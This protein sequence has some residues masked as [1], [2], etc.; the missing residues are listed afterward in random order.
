M[1]TENLNPL[2]GYFRTVGMHVTLPSGGKFFEPN[3]IEKSI[4]GEVAILPMTSA[5]EII[6]KNPDSLLNGHAIEKL[7]KSCVPGIKDPRNIPMQDMDV[8]LLAIKAC[9]YGDSLEVT[10]KCPKCES[11]TTFNMSIRSLIDGSKPLPDNNEARI[12]DDVVAYVKPYDFEAKTILDL[13]AFEETK[14]VQ[15][16]V[17]DEKISV[18]ERLER[19]NESF[20]KIAGLNL[21][22]MARCV[23]KIVIPGHVVTDPLHIREYIRNAPKNDIKKIQNAIKDLSECGVDKRVEATCSNDKC[24]HVWDTDLVFDPSHFFD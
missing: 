22:L 10:A 18:R 11:E 20:D 5:D 6:L 8:L 14:L 7:L 1:E 9:S 4:N 3:E 16:I 23:I 12:S 19:F 24:G 2:T 21:D 17:T 15:Y 13:A